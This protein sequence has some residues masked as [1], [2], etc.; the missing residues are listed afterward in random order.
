MAFIE[1]GVPFED[2]CGEE[3][4]ETM[5]NVVASQ[6]IHPTHFACPVLKHGDLYLS[7]TANILLYLASKTNIGP[8]DVKIDSFKVN[9]LQ[10]T[11]MD[12]TA[13]AHDTHHV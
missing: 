4:V 3:D 9:Q 2:K 11:I 5:M 1:A 7:Q 6:A 13:E 12:C 8:E 10:N